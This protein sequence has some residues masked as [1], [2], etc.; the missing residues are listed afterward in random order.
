MTDALPVHAGTLDARD[1]ALVQE[2]AYGTVRWRI[3]IDALLAR[4]MRHPPDDVFTHA[5]LAVGLYQLMNMRIPEHAAVAATVSAAPVKLR[6][7]V[8]GVLRNA[9]R[10]RG[11]L[12]AAVDED[13]SAS[14]AH[15]EWL[16]RALQRDWP[17]DWQSIVASDNEPAPMTLRVNLNRTRRDEYIAALERAG[18]VGHMFAHTDEG[19]VLE[20]PRP[21]TVLPGFADGL[22][23]VQDGAAQFAA[24]LLDAGPGMRVLDACAAPGG[25]TGHILERTPGLAGLVAVESDPER[26]GRIHENLARLGVPARV[27]LGDAARPSDWWDGTP[28]D[29]ILLDAP[30][31]ATGVIRRHPDIRLLRR[32]SDIA[33]FAAGQVALLEAVW[34]MLAPGGRLVYA[35]CSVLRQENE[36]VIDA[37]AAAH[38]AVRVETIDAGWGCPTHRGRQVLPGQDGM[39]GFHYACLSWN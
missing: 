8:N 37:F 33:T 13:P 34:P 24:H 2:L 9:A 35:T 36:G 1:R 14:T 19:V 11:E 23:S 27:V 26:I 22:V 31:S 16:L 17:D 12:E 10:R 3:R 5:L 29:R 18:I 32:A 30:C 28:F 6:G 39:D 4:L 7:L 38:A 15:P 21:V 20:A 25:K